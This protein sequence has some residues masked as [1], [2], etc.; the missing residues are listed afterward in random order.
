MD[1][2][3]SRPAFKTQLFRFVDVFPALD[4]REDIARHL[5]EYFDGVDIPKALDLGV[6]L[7]DRVP[8]GA[9]VE[10]RVAAQEHRSDG[11]AVHRGL[12]AGRS[13]RR[14]ARALAIG[15]RRHRR[16]ARREDRRQPRGRS[17]PGPSAR[18]PRRPLHRRAVVGAR[19][20]PGARRHRAPAPGEREHQAHGPGHPLRAAQPPRGHRVRQGAHPAHP[21][22]GARARRARALRHGALRRQGPHP[23]V[24][25]G[26]AVRGRVR[27]RGGRDRHPGL[28]ARR[29]GRP[30]RSH[31]LVRRPPHA[32]HG[33]AREGRVLGCRD[34]ARPCRGM[35]AT[36]VRE[37]GRDRRELRTMR[38]APP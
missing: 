36:G 28:P 12:D 18:A 10:S 19:R 7:A 26:P 31:R 17:L 20:P 16:P 2:A 5:T 25:P 38:P 11:R 27:R 4:G 29:Q 6:D 1:W 3:M 34:R 24:V 32:H 15:Q 22:D 9:A 21:A 30:R 23:H 8:F 13:R 37:Q 14:V 33:P 35:A